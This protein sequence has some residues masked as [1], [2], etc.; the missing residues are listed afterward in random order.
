MAKIINA[1]T[2]KLVDT[3]NVRIEFDIENLVKDIDKNGL[4]TMPVVHTIPDSDKFE[5]LQGHRRIRAVKLLPK[6]EKIE[7]VVHDGLDLKQ[8]TS[9][10]MDHGNI[11]SLSTYSEMQLAAS[12]LFKA[13]STET[14]VSNQLSGL[15]DKISPMKASERKKLKELNLAVENAVLAKNEALAEDNKK[16]VKEFIA[17]Y[18]R[19]LTQKLKKVYKA[20]KIVLAAIQ[21][22]ETG[23]KPE[24]FEE[25]EL[26]EAFPTRLI[27]K[28]EK[29]F[30]DDFDLDDKV[31][32]ELPGDA[33][34]R[35]FKGILEDDKERVIKGNKKV[36][37][38]KSLP[39]TQLQE[40]LKEAKWSSRLSRLQVKRCRGEEVPSEE[41]TQ[42][43]QFTYAC[44]FIAERDEQFA[45]EVLTQFK[46]LLEAENAAAKV[47]ATK[48]IASGKK[49]DAKVTK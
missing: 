1:Y 7:V 40:E 13:G 3:G 10:K 49:K 42:R 47:K 22:A 26:P 5:I 4:K 2:N 6:F 11:L 30:K 34:N 25:T 37:V 48:N 23:I 32:K 9:L 20:P 15:M 18:R 17:N 36:K 41:L 38:I 12:L 28:L 19:G 46:E 44:E 16:V 43:D 27:D 14:E 8:R 21:Y 31:T 39:S 29:A 24:G 35:V 33:F 45:K